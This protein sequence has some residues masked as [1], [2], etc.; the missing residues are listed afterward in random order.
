MQCSPSRKHLTD[1]C[2]TLAE[3][4]SVASL[5][6]KEASTNEKPIP[7]STFKS[8]HA[9]LKELKTR[10]KKTCPANKP[11]TCWLEQNIFKTPRAQELF[12]SLNGAYRPPKPSSWAKNEREWLNTYDILHVMKQYETPQFEFLGVFPVDFA[13]A[14]GQEQK[15]TTSKVKQCIVQQMCNF[16]IDEFK[17]RGKTTFGIVMNLDRH[18]QPGSHWVACYCCLDPDSP[19]YGICYYDSG[20]ERP[21]KPI[22][23]FIKDIY[24]Q[25]GDSGNFQKKYNPTQHQFQDTECGIFS[26]LFITFCLEHPRESYRAARKRVKTHASDPK[27][28]KIH[29]YRNLFY[30]S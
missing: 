24:D 10:F 19:K 17:A 13:Q 7:A 25:Q 23:E 15:H 20:G 9:L 26:M 4:Q 11:E 27:D 29:R 8:R 14:H 6:N 1:S 28:D 22:I 18:D 30:R 2:L 16:N 21:P 12:S 5:Y 3:L